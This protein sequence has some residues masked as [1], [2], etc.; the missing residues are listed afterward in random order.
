MR[1]SLLLRR[2]QAALI[3]RIPFHVAAEVDGDKDFDAWTEQNISAENGKCTSS[4][5]LL[6][7]RLRY[8]SSQLSHNQVEHRCGCDKLP[9]NMDVIISNIKDIE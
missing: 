3:N 2:G 9:I 5:S 1:P 4:P 8:N 6:N 7:V